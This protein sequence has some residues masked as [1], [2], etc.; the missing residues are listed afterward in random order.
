MLWRFP[1]KRFTYKCY[2]YMEKRRNMHVSIAEAHSEKIM[3]HWLSVAP[4]CSDHHQW[5]Y[6]FTNFLFVWKKEERMVTNFVEKL[7][8]WTY[9]GFNKNDGYMRKVCTKSFDG[10]N[11]KS[12]FINFILICKR[13]QEYARSYC[14]NSFGKIDGTLAKRDQ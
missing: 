3:D 13:K 14:R 12:L 2:P 11:W 7:H 9:L 4:N 1:V 8:Q 10:L 5:N 6:P